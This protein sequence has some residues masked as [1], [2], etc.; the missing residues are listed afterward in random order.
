MAGR[1]RARSLR[2]LLDMCD[3]VGTPVPAPFRTET[4]QLLMDVMMDKG[5]TGCQESR[6][7]ECF[8]PGEWHGGASSDDDRAPG[9]TKGLQASSIFRLVEHLIS[10]K[11]IERHV[12]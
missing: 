1:E 10:A 4:D 7:K 11:T 3:F 2:C 9:W 5:S 6:Q 8:V 12:T